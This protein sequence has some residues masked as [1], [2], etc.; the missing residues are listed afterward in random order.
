ME[1]NKTNKVSV[2]TTICI[3]II[4]I[5]VIALGVLYYFGFVKNNE[6]ITKL[7]SQI[8]NIQVQMEKL[9]SQINNIEI[10]TPTENITGDKNTN[11]GSSE[12]ISENNTQTSKIQIGKKYEFEIPAKYDTKGNLLEAG[13]GGSIIFN[14][15][16]TVKSEAWAI[17]GGGDGYTGTYKIEDNKITVVLLHMDDGSDYP[18]E[19]NIFIYTIIDNTQ[20]KNFKDVVYKIKK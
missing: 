12:I 15:D 1:E 10:Q 14:D 5:L 18:V 2:G 17:P 19:N 20:I 3:L 13:S 11:E 8:N 9:N 7:N 4:I 16:N 6:E